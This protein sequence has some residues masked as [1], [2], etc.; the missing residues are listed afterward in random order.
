MVIDIWRS[1]E[2]ADAADTRWA[3][4]PAAAEFMSFVDRSTMR[5]ARYFEREE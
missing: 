4:D 3:G 5:S 2:D 1:A